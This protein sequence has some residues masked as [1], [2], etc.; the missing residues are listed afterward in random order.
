MTKWDDAHATENGSE[1]AA[2][3]AEVHDAVLIAFDKDDD[4][5][6]TEV[7]RLGRVISQ[8]F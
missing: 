1:A 8:P 7:G 4:A 5:V 2:G 3:R 6:V